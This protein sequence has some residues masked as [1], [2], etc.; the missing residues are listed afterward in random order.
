MFKFIKYQIPCELKTTIPATLYNKI[1][2]GQGRNLLIKIQ[3][4][5][6]TNYSFN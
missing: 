6:E 1:K 5:Q 2:R 3:Y 4:L